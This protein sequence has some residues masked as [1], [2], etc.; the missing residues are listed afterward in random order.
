MFI[1]CPSQDQLVI[2]DKEYL[3]GSIITTGNNCSPL[4]SYI[5]DV[6]IMCLDFSHF[7]KGVLVNDP[8]CEVITAYHHPLLLF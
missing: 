8:N 2:L 1:K 7:L 3:N 6:I 4:H 5:P